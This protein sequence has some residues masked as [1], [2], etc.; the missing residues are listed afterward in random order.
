MKIITSVFSL[1]IIFGSQLTWAYDWE[2][3]EIGRVDRS[4]IQAQKTR[5]YLGGSDE[6]ELKVQ[7]ILVVPS[8]SPDGGAEMVRR[9][10]AEPDD[11]AVAPD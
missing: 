8:R 3:E 9:A 6:Q 2:E 4:A 1:V 10:D 7:K 5:S 11:H